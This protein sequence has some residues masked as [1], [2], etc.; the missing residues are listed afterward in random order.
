M[1]RGR[2]KTNL[3][4]SIPQIQ[5]YKILKQAKGQGQIMVGGGVKTTSTPQ[6]QGYKIL[7]QA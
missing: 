1:R 5:G 4:T 2:D 3:Y 6:M 7:R